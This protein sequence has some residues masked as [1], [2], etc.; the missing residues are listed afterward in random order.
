VVFSINEK[1][2]KKVG[3]HIPRFGE[4]QKGGLRI[5]PH[6][7]MASLIASYIHKCLQFTR[8]Q[9]NSADLTGGELIAAILQFLG[10]KLSM[11]L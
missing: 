9:E 7:G 11:F 5:I 6:K 8:R 1:E 3:S 4:R 2:N 10:D